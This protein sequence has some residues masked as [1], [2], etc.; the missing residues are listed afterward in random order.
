MRRL[1]EKGLRLTAHSCA[2]RSGENK[3]CEIPG[4]TLPLIFF[5][6]CD[7]RR[8]KLAIDFYL[9]GF[10]RFLHIIEDF[11]VHVETGHLESCTGVLGKVEQF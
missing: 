3:E 6:P 5:G 4:I 2:N 8:S 9:E 7:L 11:N 1:L 10:E